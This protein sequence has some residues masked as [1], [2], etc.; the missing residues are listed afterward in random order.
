VSPANSPATPVTIFI[1]CLYDVKKICPLRTCICWISLTRH[2]N[3]GKRWLCLNGT[4]YALTQHGYVRQV[5]KKLKSITLGCEKV[6]V[7]KHTCV[8]CATLCGNI[9]QPGFLPNSGN[10]RAFFLVGCGEKNR[11]KRQ[12][13]KFENL[14]LVA[15]WRQHFQVFCMIFFVLVF[16]LKQGVW[17]WQQRIRVLTRT[18]S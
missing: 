18:H 9:H 13:Q 1:L 12:S 4:Y 14:T 15:C 6:N 16:S 10:D 17:S 5:L 11:E 2:T 3:W 7:M 8:C